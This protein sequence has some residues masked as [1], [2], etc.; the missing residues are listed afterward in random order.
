MVPMAVGGAK[1]ITMGWC[2]RSLCIYICDQEERVVDGPG[3][4]G[5]SRW[6]G[7]SVTV[8]SSPHIWIYMYIYVCA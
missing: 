1:M 3:V 2:P 5:T 7:V 8:L 6:D 4:K